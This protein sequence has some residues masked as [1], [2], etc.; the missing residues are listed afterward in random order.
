MDKKTVIY[1][2]IK[3]IMKK[4]FN[5]IVHDKTFFSE[6]IFGS[7]IKLM[8]RDLIYLLKIIEKKYNFHILGRDIEKYKLR[9]FENIVDLLLEKDLML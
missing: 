5:I 1:E 9:T 4:E 2:E 8:P 6:N 3:D 7:K